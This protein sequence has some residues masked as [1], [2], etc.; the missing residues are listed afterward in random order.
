MAGLLWTQVGSKRLETP[1]TTGPSNKRLASSPAENQAA[2]PI[3]KKKKIDELT[4]AQWTIVAGKKRKKAGTQQ[5]VDTTPQ[6]GNGK[7]GGQHSDELVPEQ[8]NMI[9][10]LPGN[11]NRSR[12]VN[13]LLMQ[14]IGEMEADMI[15]ISEQY[16][17]RD[18]TAWFPHSLGI[19]AIWIPNPKRVPINMHG[20]KNGFVWVKSKGIMYVSCYLT[21]N[22]SIIEFQEKLDLLED[23][24]REEEGMILLAGDLNARAVEWG[25]PQPDSRG[26]RIL[27]MAARTGLVM[28]NKG[29]K[30]TFRRTGQKGSIPDITLASE[31]LAP[32]IQRW[33]VIEDYTGSDHQY[34]SFTVGNAPQNGITSQRKLGWN[35][36]KMNE[37]LLNKVI[38]EGKEALISLYN[39]G[40]QA[41][42]VETLVDA[43]MQLI[44]RA[45]DESM[46]RKIV[47]NR[48]RTNYWWTDK[49]AELRR[50]CL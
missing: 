33:H 18:S 42:R 22:E 8:P 23:A 32:L 21:P 9:R 12:T 2:T 1:K 24:I 31:S 4:P 7:N 45:C 14:L 13:D 36:T 5:N 26:K 39:R 28:I 20:S 6:R 47:H 49:I 16:Q 43:T 29:Q 38:T 27:E 17:E 50:K 35:T 10:I 30:P 25:V 44:H 37:E 11:L 40:E 46:P 3:G 48:R 41:M 15:I 34:M 19:A